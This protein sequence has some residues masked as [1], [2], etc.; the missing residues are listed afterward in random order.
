MGSKPISKRMTVI[1]EGDQAY[2]RIEAFLHVAGYTIAKAFG[3][4]EYLLDEKNRWKE[5][6]FS[7]VNDFLA[8]FNFKEIEANLE[9]RKRLAKRIKELQ[10]DATG[11]QIARTV[12]LSETTNRDARNRADGNEKSQQTQ[13]ES[14]RNRAALSGAEAAKISE[15]AESKA[16]AAQETAAKR[17]A[18]RSAPIVQDGVDLRIGDCRRVLADIPD[19]SVPLILTDPPYAAEAEPLYRWLAEWSARV[20]IPGGSLI[21]Y[22]G[23]WSINRDTRI[24]DEY[25]RYWWLLIMMHGQSQR[26]A[27]KFVIANFKPVL[28]YVKGHRRGRTL[29]P[30]ILHSVQRDKE[31]HDWGQGEGGVSQIIEHLTEP[32]EL[33]IDPFAG[34]ARWGNIAVSMGRRW[35]GADVVQG[36]ATEVVATIPQEEEEQCSVPLR[37]VETVERA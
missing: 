30:D 26:L 7:N 19:N 28:W 11:R 34:T 35:T 16:A 31:M 25:L 1:R 13:P 3:D 14:A 4:M 36:G 29:M 6:G 18:S 10:P 9:T 32:G 37:T 5:F 33:I 22:T 27:G 8:S 15:R 12:G 2:G 24:F 21:C 17:E 20:L 23:H